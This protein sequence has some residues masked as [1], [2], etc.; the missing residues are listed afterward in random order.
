MAFADDL[1]MAIARDNVIKLSTGET[2]M[3]MKALL[4]S[5]RKEPGPP[6][7]TKLA[8]AEDEPRPIQDSK[9]PTP[10]IV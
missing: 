1:L 8:P 10:P 7:E 6:P 9:Q 2:E 3:L 4:E 5:A